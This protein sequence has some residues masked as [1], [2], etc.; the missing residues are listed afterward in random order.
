M[1]ADLKSSI[2]QTPTEFIERQGSYLVNETLKVSFQQP[3]YKNLVSISK[4]ALSNADPE[5][6]DICFVQEEFTNPDAFKI[7]CESKGITIFTST[8]R[9]GLFA[10]H[11][12]KQILA[13]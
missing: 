8:P 5:H 7:L 4:L 13:Y 9:A 12:L 3:S 1:I 11:L 2:F 10:L 6:A